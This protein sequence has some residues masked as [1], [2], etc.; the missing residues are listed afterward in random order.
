VFGGRFGALA[1]VLAL[2]SI[3]ATTP[4]TTAQTLQWDRLWGGASSDVA[5][6]VAVSPD[7]NH[8]YIAGY[9][10][11]FG[12]GNGD[13]FLAKYTSAGSIV[14]DELW[15]GTGYDY[16]H[17]IVASPGGD[18]V[19]IAGGTWSFGAGYNDAFLARYGA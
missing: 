13:A 16:E 6:G 9:A 4:L 8:V 10:H 2:A 12:A 5:W 7:G 15:G 17:S 1:L 3:A 18:S 19:Y 11:S 14:W